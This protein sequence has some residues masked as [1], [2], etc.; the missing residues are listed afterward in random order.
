MVFKQYNKDDSCRGT[1]KTGMLS[2]IQLLQSIIMGS[3]FFWF[4]KMNTYFMDLQYPVFGVIL[5]IKN[6]VEL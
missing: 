3:R 5:T 2:F 1:M 4:N 6:F